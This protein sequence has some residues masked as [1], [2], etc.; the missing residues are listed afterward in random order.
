VTDSAVQTLGTVVTAP[1]PSRVVEPSKMVLPDPSGIAATAETSSLGVLVKAAGGDCVRD[2]CV[3]ELSVP[4]ACQVAMS[5]PLEADFHDP[6]I[7]SRPPTMPAPVSEPM[8]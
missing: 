1:F 7:T 8:S 5:R 6:K 4:P 3:A 2:H